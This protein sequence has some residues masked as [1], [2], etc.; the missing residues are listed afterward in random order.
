M[1]LE[2]LRIRTAPLLHCLLPLHRGLGALRSLAL[3]ISLYQLRGPLVGHDA[4]RVDER[5]ARRAHR[6][7]VRQGGLLQV[8]AVLLFAGFSLIEAN[9][10]RISTILL[11]R[12]SARSI[13]FSL[14]SQCPP[15]KLH[16]TRVS[17]PRNSKTSVPSCICQMNSR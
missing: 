12:V 6:L 14:T 2:L 8:R 15:K 1:N 16:L 10:P 11:P 17:V 3:W 5:L 7:E 9:V 13:F 4:V